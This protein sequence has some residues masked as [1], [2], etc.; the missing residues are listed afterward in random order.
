MT[1]DGATVVYATDHEPFWN[2][3]GPACR[4]IRATSATS[5]FLRGANLVIHDAQ[6]TDDEYRDKVGWGHSSIEYA[7]DVALAAGVERLVLFHH[8]PAHDDA[9]MEKM[10]SMARSHV[11]RRGQALDVLAARE[12]MELAVVGSGI[13]P[14]VGEASALQ[15]R[16][17]VGGR[18]LVVSANEAECAEIEEILSDDGLILL[19][20]LRHAGGAVPRPRAHAR[21]RDRRSRAAGRR[22]R[23]DADV[24]AR[25]A[26]PAELSD[27]RPRR[28]LD[29]VRCGVPR[30]GARRPT[31][32]PKPFSPPMLRARVRAWLARTLHGRSTPAE[33]GTAGIERGSGSAADRRARCASLLASVPLF[34]QL[35]AEQR[36]L[37]LNGAA[38]QTFAPGH[39]LIRESDAPERLYVILSGRVRVLEVAPDSPVELIVGELG[40]GEIIGELSMLRNLTRSATVVAVERTH[41]LVLPQSEFL[42]VLHS[43]TDLAVSLLR[44]LAGRLYETDRR[45]SRYAPDPVTGPGGSPRFPRSISAAGRRRAPPQDG[46]APAG[47]RRLPAQGHQRPLGLRDRR[48]RPAHRRGRARRGHADDGPD[49]PPRRRRVRHLL[50]GRRP[51]RRRHRHR[52]GPREDQVA[53]RPAGGSGGRA[54]QFRRRVRPG[55]SRQRRGAPARGRP[56]HAAPQA[57][58]GGRLLKKA[59]LLRWRPRLHAQRTASTPRVQPSGAASRLDLFEQPASASSGSRTPGSAPARRRSS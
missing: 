28:Q 38:E 47:R 55:A 14:A 7:V 53:G 11:G 46:R 52:P 30:R 37:L 13:V 21:H 15:H 4:S 25:A 10:E 3:S 31:I 8:D 43:S 22:R 49:R 33:R 51:R 48:R 34:R 57:V 12:G 24:A 35:I 26:R 36:D 16:Q 1:G 59:H 23:P 32:S 19:R 41:C 58:G 29:S 42:K 9:M 27:H 54:L 56:G 44:M 17:I 5:T 39:V 6:Y 45:L 18:V 50:P 20:R 40:E 2:A